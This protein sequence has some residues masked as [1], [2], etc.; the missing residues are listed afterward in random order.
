MDTVFKA[1]ADPTRRKILQLLKREE[2]TP[3]DL[4]EHFALSG[5]SLSHHLQILL[6]AELVTVRKSG[7][8]RIYMVNQSIF[9]QVM[10]WVLSMKEK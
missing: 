7:Q 10:Q 3:G 8:Q 6:H 5:A 2:M 9:E 4:L 1:L